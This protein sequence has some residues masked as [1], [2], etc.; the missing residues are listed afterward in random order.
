MK[1]SVRGTRRWVVALGILV[2]VIMIAAV[3]YALDVAANQQKI[4]R[5]IAV[6][7]VD[8][9][10]MERSAAV[11]EL[12]RRL[13]DAAFEPVVIRAG[14]QESTFIPDD[15]GL[16]L[17]FDEAVA[18]IP[19]PSLNPIIRLASFFAPVKDYDV[20]PSVNPERLS[21]HADELAQQLSHE[22]VD[23][24]VSLEHGSVETTPAQPGQEVTASDVEEALRSS[25]WLNPDGV[26]VAATTIDPVIDDAAVSAFARGDAA[27]AVSGPLEVRGRNEVTATASPADI[28]SFVS[29]ER[30]GTALALAIDTEAAQAFFEEGLAATIVPGRNA[31]ISFSGG[32]RTVTAHTDGV[33]VDWEPTLAPLREHIL[34]TSNR[35]WDAVYRDEPAQFTTA[36]AEAARFDQ[37]VG[38]FSTSGY[39][40]ASGRNIEIVASVVNGAV[41]APGE[42]FSLNGYTGPRGTAQGYVE[43]G[44]ILDGR[45]D[46]AVGGG[47]SQF[48]T[49]L[50][51]AAYFA[52]MEDV[53]HTPHSYYI[54]R[55]PAGREATVYE[56]AIDL[57]FKNTAPTPVMISTSFGGGSISV[58][59]MGVK[60]V[61]V[62]SVNNGRWAPTQPQ[63]RTVSG[64]ECVP[65]SGAPG[66]T[67]SDTRI[68][69]SL[70][71]AE[72]SRETITT[73]YNPQPII[74]C[75]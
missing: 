25:Q 4:P 3:A 5:G 13:G 58:R 52:G 12:D 36:D 49:T 9:S 33:T 38:E 30:Q 18:A 59:I 37:V 7:G 63:P 45:A 39:S 19:E 34:S 62:E 1:K 10:T 46:T 6:G 23:G 28:S 72:L 56:G 20:E 43:S 57:V 74:R 70:S 41:I 8:I 73:V 61:T 44:V 48:A 42:T 35:S 11:A 2:G 21:R 68:I 51:N 65:S 54:S 27:A 64:P 32:T 31:Q 22:A 71:G 14:S 15:A 24:S 67:T 40:A 69:R 29:V 53:S 66:F 50:Y 60:Y 75:A 17:D 55:Y 26:E 16:G 47:I